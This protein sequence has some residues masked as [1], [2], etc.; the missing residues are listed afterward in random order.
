M[1]IGNALSSIETR[2]IFKELVVRSII[3]KVIIVRN[4][5]SSHV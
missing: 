1:N 4:S 3:W 5:I 2:S